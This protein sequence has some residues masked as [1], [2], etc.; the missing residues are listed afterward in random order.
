MLIANQD[1]FDYAIYTAL[2]KFGAVNP[3]KDFRSSF[4]LLGYSGP[5]EL[6]AVTQV[7]K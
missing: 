6:D 2:T 3:I 5:G 4:A 1:A 7:M